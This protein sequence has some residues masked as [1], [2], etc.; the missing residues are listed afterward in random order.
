MSG[1][2]RAMPEIAPEQA[3]VVNVRGGARVC[4]LP[5]V[6]QITP[7]ALLRSRSEE[8]LNPEFWCSPSP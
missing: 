6:E 2:P 4:V 1:L 3:L 8:N 7:Y 5:F